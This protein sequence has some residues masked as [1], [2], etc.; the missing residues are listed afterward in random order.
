M[1]VGKRLVPGRPTIWMIVGQ[2]S[3]VFSEGAVEASVFFLC[4]SFLVFFSFSLWETIRF[5]LKYYLKGL[6]NP[7]QQTNK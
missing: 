2:G 4:L 7:K 1:V 3:A 6:I 5:R